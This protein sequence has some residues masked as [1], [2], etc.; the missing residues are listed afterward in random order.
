MRHFAFR[1]DSDGGVSAMIWL[2]DTTN[3][4]PLVTECPCGAPRHRI[5]QNRC[6]DCWR[7]FGRET[8][9]ISYEDAGIYRVRGLE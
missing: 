2:G 8:Q 5:K 9:E 3:F 4:C 6:W 7:D 1:R